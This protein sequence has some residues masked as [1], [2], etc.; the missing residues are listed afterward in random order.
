MLQWKSVEVNKNKLE[1]EV[2]DD[3]QNLHLESDIRT[4]PPPPRYI[5]PNTSRQYHSPSRP[6]PSGTPDFIW[7]QV[8][9]LPSLQFLPYADTLP[10]V[11]EIGLQSVFQASAPSASTEFILLSPMALGFP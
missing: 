2:A 9:V 6:V 11:V 3:L 1:D 5:Q 7:D 10:Y 8:C 4:P